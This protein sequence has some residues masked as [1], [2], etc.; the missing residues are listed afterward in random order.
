MCQLILMSKKIDIAAAQANP[1]RPVAGA[2][3]SAHLSPLTDADMNPESPD[4]A[5]MDTLLKRVIDCAPIPSCAI[6]TSTFQVLHSNERYNRLMERRENGERRCH[7]LMYGLDTPCANCH[8]RPGGSE[9]PSGS[10]GRPVLAQG[11][12]WIPSHSVIHLP[13]RAPLCLVFLEASSK[14]AS[15][16]RENSTVHVDELTGLLNHLGYKRDGEELY[17]NALEQGLKLAVIALKLDGL[18]QIN[19]LYGYASGDETLRLFANAIL[20]TLPR[21]A[22]LARL[23]RNDF[24]AL[25]PLEDAIGADDMARLLID[26]CQ[27]PARLSS[28]HQQLSLCQVFAGASVMEH[29]ESFGDLNFLAWDACSRTISDAEGP[30]EIVEGEQIAQRITFRNLKND[31]SGAIASH[32]MELL[33]QPKIDTTTG[34]QVGAEALIRWNHDIR[35]QILPGEFIPMAERSGQIGIIDTWVIGETC[36]TLR[37]L[38]NLNVPLMPLSINVSPR[39]FFDTRLEKVL[40]DACEQYDIAPSLIELELTERTALR[41]IGLTQNIMRRLRDLGFGMAMDDF[42]VGYSSLSNLELL[43]FGTIKVDRSF[44]ANPSRKTRKVIPS[45]VSLV[46]NHEMEIV[47]EGVE[48]K[49]QLDMVREAGCRY[50][51]GFYFSRPLSFAA[52]AEKLRQIGC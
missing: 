45:I 44:I 25:L 16:P 4:V 49:E 29:D 40:L 6:D 38:K 37:Q 12:T 20:A 41:N 43:P 27:V 34:E 36:R 14:P 22:L 18:Y 19:T 46:R 47:I 9:S 50:I 2:F 23:R 7:A 24:S 31:L 28:S 32:R 26:I 42:G 48:T 11:G 33:Y 3:A 39:T 15:I 30:Y 13:R 8:A 35:G 52:L 5:D 17:L 51:Q 21:N 10:R 1:A